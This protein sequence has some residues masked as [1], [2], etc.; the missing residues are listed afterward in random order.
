[1]T[2]ASPPTWPRRGASTRW[3]SARPSRRSWPASPTPPTRSTPTCSAPSTAFERARRGERLPRL[4]LDQ[5]RLPGGPAA[6]ARAGGGRDPLRAGRVPAGPRRRPSGHLRGLPA[7]RAAHALRRHQARRRAADRG[8]RRCLR[9]TRRDQS[10]RR[11]RRALADGQGRPGRLL[12]VAARP[13]LRP[14]ALLHRLSAAR[15]SR[16]ATCCT[17][18]T[19]S[20]WST[21]SSPIPTRWSGVTANVGGGREGSLSLLETTELCRELTGNE[22]PIGTEAETRPGDVPIYLSDCSHLRS[23]TSWRPRREPARGAR[24]PA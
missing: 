12:L 20:T 2:C 11:D 1:M 17:S 18:T 10:L 14:A 9:A 5:P 19:W 3:S 4:P 7:G 6:R 15:A 23:L 22:V 13:P 8:V 16:C 24:R 21:S